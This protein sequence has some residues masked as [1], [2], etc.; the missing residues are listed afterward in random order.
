[1]RFVSVPACAHPDC[2]YFEFQWCEKVGK[3]IGLNDIRDEDTGVDKFPDFCPLPGP[4][5]L[6]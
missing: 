5:N 6:A 1:M 2:P 3:E 4:E